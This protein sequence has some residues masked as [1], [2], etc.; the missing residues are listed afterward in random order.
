MLPTAVESSDPSAAAA[1]EARPL[2]ELRIGLDVD[3]DGWVVLPEWF[4]VWVAG[5]GTLSEIDQDSGEV[6]RTGTGR[7]DY[8][9]VQLARYGEGTIL[10]ASGSTL[11]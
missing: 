7:W 8:D 9:H 1:S 11:W 6:R 2:L 4:G 5:A 3:A 10:L